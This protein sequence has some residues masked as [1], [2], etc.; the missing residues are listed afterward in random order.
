MLKVEG[1]SVRFGGRAALDGVSFALHA[2]EIVLVSGPSGCG[3]STLAR[4]LNGLI[5]HCTSARMDGRVWVGG[6]NT[7]EHPVCELAAVA[8]VVLQHPE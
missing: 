3:K 1:L 2:G 5:P 4:C 8:G 7:R 6:L